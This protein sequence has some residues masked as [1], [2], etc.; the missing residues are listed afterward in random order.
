VSALVPELLVRA[1]GKRLRLPVVAGQAARFAEEAASAG[2]GALEF[3]AALLSA[4]VAQR[5]ANVERS[6]I[7]AARFPEQKELSEFDFGAIPSLNAALV[8]E[9]ARGAYLE[10]RETVLLVGPPGTGKT[11]TATALGLAACRMG[12]RVRFVT[13]AGLV[14][15]LAEA[16]AEHRL[17]RLEAVLDRI[18]LL[19]CDEL[20]FVRLDPDQAQLLFTLLAHRYTRGALIVTSNLEFADWTSVF[21]GDE[22]LTAALLDRLTHR[23]HLLEFRG[24]SYRF[25]QSLAA[26]EGRLDGAL[27]SSTT[28]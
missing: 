19:I 12:K 13:V 17:S 26:R 7:A 5:D 16:Q 27:V 14:T 11:H 4:E 18:D 2:H 10:R 3:L 28:D 21:A 22:R 25:R 9:L 24:S 23:C 8:A 6:R 15:E 20:G 1:H